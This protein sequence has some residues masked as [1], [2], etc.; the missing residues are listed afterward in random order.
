VSIL[1][2][3]DT[4]KHPVKVLALCIVRKPCARLTSWRMVSCS[5]CCL[6]GVSLSA[7]GS[8]HPP[9]GRQVLTSIASLFKVGFR[10]ERVIKDGVF[11]LST[12]VKV[13]ESINQELRIFRVCIRS[14][15]VL[16]APL[17]TIFAL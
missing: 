11:Q 7:P 17:V 13:F 8:A 4:S 9:I 3:Q 10:L 15:A 1:D 5:S 12:T 6:V 2:L 16:L 14:A